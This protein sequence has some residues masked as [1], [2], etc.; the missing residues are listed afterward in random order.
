MIFVLKAIKELHIFNFLLA[1]PQCPIPTAFS[2]KEEVILSRYTENWALRYT[3]TKY[4]AK[5]LRNNTLNHVS[6]DLMF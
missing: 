3:E 6:D 4:D 5:L 1:R 2:R